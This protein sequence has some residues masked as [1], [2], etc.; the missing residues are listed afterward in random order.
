MLFNAEK[1]MQQL[2]EGIEGSFGKKAMRIGL[3]VLPNVP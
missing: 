2:R 3:L 1:L